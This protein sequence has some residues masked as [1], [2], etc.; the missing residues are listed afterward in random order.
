MRVET[1]EVPPVPD[2]HDHIWQIMDYRLCRPIYVSGIDTGADLAVGYNQM[3]SRHYLAF[4][5]A[6][7][8]LRSPPVEGPLRL[9]FNCNLVLPLI[10]IRRHSTS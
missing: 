6:R 7:W 1:W 9:N 8:A 5:R 2:H 3:P 10:S 4:R